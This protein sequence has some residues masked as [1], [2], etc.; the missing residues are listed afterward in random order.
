ML[1]PMRS[2][3][4]LVAGAFA[5]LAPAGA[6]AQ[7]SRAL[8]EASVAVDQVQGQLKAAEDNLR[9]VETQW[10]MHPEPSDEE[11]L[12]RRFSDGEIQYLLGDTLGA[13]VLFYDVVSDPKFQS[14]A[15]M[16]DALFYLADSLYQ[17]GNLLGSRVYLKQL[18]AMKSAHHAEALS[19][20]LDVA[21]RTNEF[22]GIEGYI[23]EV[24]GQAGALPPEIAYVYGKWLFRRRDLP[25][26]ERMQ[27]LEQT[28]AAI[29]DDPEAP[30]RLQ[31]SYFL[32]VAYT[33]AK[34]LDRAVAQFQKL[35]SLP[36]RGE[37]EVKIKEL[38][39]LSLGRLYYELGHYDDALDR[40]QEI[41]RESENFPDS[42]YEIAWCQVKKGEFERA[43]NATDILLLVAPDSTLAPE[44]KILQ[45]HLLLKLKKYVEA[46]DTYDQVVNEYSP[47]YD[48]INA[49]LT[50]EDPVSYFDKLLARNEKNLDVASLLPAEALKWATTQKEVSDAV[51][52][53]N[54]LESGRRGIEEA[55]DIAGRVLKALEERGMESFPQIQEGYVRAEAVEAALTR[56]ELSLVRAETLVTQDGLDDKEK[57]E[58]EKVKAQIDQLQRRF[59]SV[60]T[61]Q[62]EIEARRRKMQ[63]RVDAADKDAFKA[64]YELQSLSAMLVAMGKWVD[65]NRNAR[66][67]TPEDEKAFRARVQS[68]LE[69]VETMSKE[70]TSLRSDLAQE[71]ASVDASVS[72]ED[73]LRKEY[74]AALG[75]Q[76]QLLG[77]AEA[78]AGPDARAVLE[79]AHRF[80]ATAG[81]LKDRVGTAKGVLREQ[82]TRRGKQLKEKVLGEQQLLSQYQ[83]NVG[84]VSGDA[85]NLVGRIAFDS[86]KRVRQQFYDLVLKANVGNVDVAFTRKQ[87]KTQQIQKLS[88]EKD[89][90]LRELDGEFKEVLKDVD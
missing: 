37:K 15:R 13:S 36:A 51:R 42:L 10:T 1:R 24:R 78:K 56:T 40:Y 41:P 9:I 45:G 57:A 34:S 6:R 61:T 2:R 59:A 7:D 89:R 3:A 74:L 60:P 77:N 4:A 32:G 58:L 22:E 73:A 62:S 68:E 65:D 76:H 27:R 29:A 21:G 86:F 87:D 70:L 71:R 55:K 47:V 80:R 79:R 43:K 81:G 35:L 72:G 20:F 14:S 52:M 82:L 26:P 85:R 75:R 18:L 8:T 33:Q 16:P 12:L 19:R 54:D 64:G 17:S 38:A 48:E 90:E 46:D 69:V 25:P 88:S 67:S 39:N 84:A 63:Q 83:S 5:L 31:S 30:Y 66:K 49:L 11:T 50:V 23:N 53:I 44:A 28:F